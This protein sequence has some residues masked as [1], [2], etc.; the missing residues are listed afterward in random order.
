MNYTIRNYEPKDYDNV[1][2]ICKET[3]FDSYK[4][5][6]V[7]L[8]TVPIMF[9]D[10]FIDYEPEYLFVA[11]DEEDRAV[12]YIECATEYRSFVKTMK[13]EYYPRLKKIDPKQIRFFNQFLFA[14]WF[15]RKD[16][17]HLHIDLTASAQHQGLGT[18]LMNTLI[19]K[20]KDDGFHSLSICANSRK[21]DGY[22]FYIKYGFKEIFDY[23][24]DVVSLN[25]K[26]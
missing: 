23:G 3:A 16:A 26:F 18:K 11:V 21:S 2:N 1:H 4:K 17:C 19:A 8:E 13:K 25:I 22:P 10:Y 7:K 14:L 9:L 5:D 20:L 24:K 6:P 15:I 12:G